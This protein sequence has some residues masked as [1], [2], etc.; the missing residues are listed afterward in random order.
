MDKMEEKD[1]KIKYKS[2]KITEKADKILVKMNFTAKEWL[3]YKKLCE[4]LQKT[5]HYD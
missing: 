3:K 1:G 5:K 2:L 4:D